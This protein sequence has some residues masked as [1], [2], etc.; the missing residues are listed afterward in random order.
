MKKIVYSLI[1]LCALA[2]STAQASID[3]LGSTIYDATQEDYFSFQVDTAG[4]VNIYT[5]SLA[6]FDTFLTFWSASSATP[7]TAD[8][9]LLGSN[10]NTTTLSG[11][12]SGFNAKDAQ[13]KLTLAA[14]NYLARI[15]AIGAT[16][17]DYIFNV[18]T[19]NVAAGTGA[20][21]SN[22]T[23]A[24]APAAVPLPAAVWM[25]GTGL[26]G[27]LGFAKRKGQLQKAIC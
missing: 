10:D 8:L 5:S 18:D 1:A 27:F 21:I 16:P 20:V 17:F 2:T 19:D 4:D 13:L 25:F 6:P 26:M 24:V 15:T 12:E 23:T 3:T 9:T 7:T 14:G 11:F 22:L